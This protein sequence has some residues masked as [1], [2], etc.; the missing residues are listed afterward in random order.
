M[1]LAKTKAQK[2]FAER[3]S[4]N[5]KKINDFLLFLARRRSRQNRSAFLFGNCSFGK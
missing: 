3:F 2:D 4:R 1:F 5:G